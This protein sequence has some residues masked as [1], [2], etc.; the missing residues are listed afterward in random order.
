MANTQQ[1]AR[2]E[3]LAVIEPTPVCKSPLPFPDLL[4]HGQRNELRGGAEGLWLFP[5][6][7]F[8]PAREV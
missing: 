6:S 2:G 3:P 4:A 1:R 5:Y 7:G 8:L